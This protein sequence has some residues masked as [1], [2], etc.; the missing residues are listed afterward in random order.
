[1]YVCKIHTG[2]IQAKKKKTSLLCMHIALACVFLEF[3]ICVCTRCLYAWPMRS[4]LAFGMRT[5]VCMYVFS[6]VIVPMACACLGD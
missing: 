1:M 4:F 3:N 2:S 5:C 6:C